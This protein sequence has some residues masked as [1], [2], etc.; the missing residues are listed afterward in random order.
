MDS[1]PHCTDPGM[2]GIQM[3][4]PHV[5]LFNLF[6]SIKV[7]HNAWLDRLISLIAKGD[8][9]K[10]E[11]HKSDDRHTKEENKTRKQDNDITK[12]ESK[13]PEQNDDVA[14]KESEIPKPGKDSPHKGGESG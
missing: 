2:T 4:Q 11:T 3:C 10:S 6:Y 14:R 8:K 1:C 12:T 13:E 9:K 7:W 5:G